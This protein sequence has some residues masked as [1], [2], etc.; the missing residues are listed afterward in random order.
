LVLHGAAPKAILDLVSK[1]AGYDYVAI[2]KAIEYGCVARPSSAPYTLR[3][4]PYYVVG[5]SLQL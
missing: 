3:A 4:V 1:G 5:Q 2:P